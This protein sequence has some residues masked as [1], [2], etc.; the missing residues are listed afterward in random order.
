MRKDYGRDLA[1]V[2]FN[3]PGNVI[4]GQAN[5]E[6]ARALSERFGKILQPKKSV[7][8]NSRDTSTSESEHLD[9]AIPASKISS[10]PSG[11]FVCLVADNPANKILLKAFLCEIQQD[12]QQIDREVAAY[13]QLPV[14]QALDPYAVD[15]NFNKIKK[16]VEKIVTLQ[17]EKMSKSP[18]LSKLFIIKTEEKRK[19]KHK[20]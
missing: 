3:L 19:L 8:T 20:P 5:G 15:D 14:V 1:D 11:E 16:D 7:S 4:C 10:L 18:Q 12:Q 9:H 2:L 6:T 13:Q 17:I